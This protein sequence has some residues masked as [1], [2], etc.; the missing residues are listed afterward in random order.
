[1]RPGS[2]KL[3]P[4]PGKVMRLHMARYATYVLQARSAPASYA[5]K[6][7]RRT[8]RAWYLVSARSDCVPPFNSGAQHG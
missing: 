6:L 3:M 5:W 1:M 8:G 2:A 7:S 4:A